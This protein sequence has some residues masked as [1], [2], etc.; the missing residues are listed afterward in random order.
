M[1][2]LILT[3]TLVALAGLA[4]AQKDHPTKV[5]GDPITTPSGLEYWDITVG[6]GTVAQS[7]QH[8]KVDYTGWLTNGKKFDSSVGTGRPF[9]FML[10]AGQVI[11]GW[12][13][14]VAGMKVGGNRQLHI[15]PDLAYGEKGSAGVIP[16]NSTLIFDVHLVDVDAPAGYAP[17]STTTASQAAQSQHNPLD[18]MVQIDNGITSGPQGE[19]TVP[20]PPKPADDGPSLEVTMKFIQ[21]KLN[22]IGPVNFAV[23]GHDDAGG[24]DST[25]QQKIEVTKVFADPG[26]CLIKYRWNWEKE[27]KVVDDHDGGFFLK[28]VRD[29]A[30]TPLDQYQ[31]KFVAAA[32]HPSW[33][34][35]DDPAVFVLEVR[36]SETKGANT[37]VFFDEQ[38]ANR[39]AKALVHAVELCGGGT[40]PEPF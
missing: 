3:I 8:V 12:D 22:D 32:G 34:Y 10:G 13:E 20:P 2:T 11:R 30:V 18:L 5:T 33:N 28:T 9:E 1:K 4:T 40:K 38:L 31:K 16:A 29:I 35:R 25:M 15:P 7:G 37:L 36:K 14:G 23:Y 19:K 24:G 27:G 21:D 6:T 39:V 17:A 26:A